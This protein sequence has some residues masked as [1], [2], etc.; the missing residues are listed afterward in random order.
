MASPLAKAAAATK[1]VDVSGVKGTGPN[2]R[3]LYADVV[4]ASVPQ[5]GTPCIFFKILL[6]RDSDSNFN[7]Y[8]CF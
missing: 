5:K 2:G 1:G 4:E 3:V 7:S 6:I 8:S